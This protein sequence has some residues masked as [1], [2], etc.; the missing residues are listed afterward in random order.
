[1]KKYG[2]LSIVFIAIFVWGI[3]FNYTRRYNPQGSEKEIEACTI[4]FPQAQRFSGKF[5]NPPHYKAYKNNPQTGREELSG[6]VVITTD[7]APDIKGYAGPVKIAVGVDLDG[8]INALYILSHGETSP[9]VSNLDQFIAQFSR[10]NFKND[11][12]PGKDL[13]GIT[14][15]TITSEA[16]ARSVERSLKIIAREVLRLDAASE[17]QQQQK[18]PFDQIAVPASV[19]TAA[20][21]GFVFHSNILRW[22]AMLGGLFYLGFYKKTMVSVVDVANIGLWKIPD[23][24]GIPLWY[25][26]IIPTFISAILLGMVYCGNICPFAGVQELLFNTFRKIWPRAQIINVSRNIDRPARYIKYVVLFAVL[27]ASF[28][29]G[30]SNPANV[31]VFVMFFT[32]RAS[33]LGWVLV[34]SVLTI[35]LFHFRFWC[36]YLCPMGAVCG[37]FSRVSLFRIKAKGQCDGCA[38]CEKICPV[39]AITVNQSGKPEIDYPECIQCGRCLQKCPRAMLYLGGW[40]N[41]KQ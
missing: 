29:L 14:G 21:F 3:F 35:S 19:F 27:I 9:Y 13:D 40:R 10:L 25:W 16:I 32:A 18:I 30:N 1:M 2:F 26:L 15:A 6:V 7:L 34:I 11:F 41:E 24:A 8:N 22:M 31:E 33:K 17:N 12:K 38:A 28:I 37:L 5:S 39:Q 23:L 20:V 36:K 4:V